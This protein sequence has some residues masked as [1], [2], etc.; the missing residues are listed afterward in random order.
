[1]RNDGLIGSRLADMR[2]HM[3]NATKFNG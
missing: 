1:L 3:Y 2:R